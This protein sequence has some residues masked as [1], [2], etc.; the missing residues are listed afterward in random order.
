M[1]AEV[2]N[3]KRDDAHAATRGAGADAV[4]EPHAFRWRP[5]AIVLG[6]I[7]SL[8][9]FTFLERVHENPRLLWA[10]VGVAAALLAW[11]AALFV[12]A[13]RK[14]RSLGV[15]LVPPVRSHYVQ[16]SVQIAIYA[17]WGWYWR[18]MYAE[19]PLFAAQLVLLYAFEAMLAWA[20]G[21]NWRPGFGLWP[22]IFSTNFF[23]WFRDDWFIFQFIM[24]A[25]CVMSKE[26]VRWRRDGRMTHIFNPSAFGLT[27]ASLALIATGTT[28]ELS[29][30]RELATTIE[31]PPHI[32]L[33]IFA[34]GLVV[35]ALFSVTLMTLSATATLCV[36]NLAYTE[37]TGVYQFVTTNISAAV[38]LGIHLLFTDPATS[39]RSNLGRAAFGVLYGAGNWVL[40]D[41]LGAFNVP[42]LYTKLLLVP[43][44]NLM[45]PA[46]DATAR[47]GLF[48]VIHRAW[49]TALAPWKMNFVHI[50]VWAAIFF[51]MLGTGFVEGPHP[52]NSIEFWKKAYA[53]GRHRAGK[54]LLIVT[55]VQAKDG[56]AAAV[57]ELGLLALDEAL[58][59]G[60]VTDSHAAAAGHFCDA[61]AMG[62]PNGCANVALQFLLMR[63]QR[64][65]ED[66]D[67]ALR[68]IE[69]GCVTGAYPQACALLGFAHETGRGRPVDRALALQLYMRCPPENLF[70]CK[71]IARIALA[72]GV[73]AD[74]FRIAP[75]LRG[76]A[77]AGDP[78]SCWYL[79]FM[80]HLGRGVPASDDEARRFFARACSLGY[81]HA[82]ALATQSN[83]PDYSHPPLTFP[84]WWTAFPV[85]NK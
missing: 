68:F 42:E 20:R 19:G 63:E 23:L 50:G 85:G 52:G 4:H 14:R 82:C 33:C 56:S 32:F 71:G 41:V 13:I 24:V 45:V 49:E 38:F 17:Y 83:L 46:I 64:S 48:A 5:A 26:F 62:D 35:Q 31:R 36:L 55:L 60:I 37:A 65:A 3:A 8:L 51:G 73:N 79:A 76:A 21:R 40:F 25:A 84:G 18:E 66:T 58:V 81:Q 74:L 54:R 80:H 30:A 22:I 44:L 15:E 12:L 47:R 10:F 7:A 2:R 78:E 59:K 34:A 1:S 57:N 28:T 77:D 11:L 69:D 43:M 67:R 27:L 9:A 53:E 39:P 61:C 70:A 72:D 75:T 6:L 29:W 16:A